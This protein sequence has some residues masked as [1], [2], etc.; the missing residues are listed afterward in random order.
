MFA[1]I[2]RASSA[3]EEFQQSQQIKNGENDKAI[4]SE[5]NN[6][7][8]DRPRNRRNA[9]LLTIFCVH[10]KLGQKS[11]MDTSGYLNYGGNRQERDSYN[12]IC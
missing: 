8:R 3:H 9:K 1:A 11:I 2:R 5:T 10:A 6:Y 7:Y 4:E 12:K